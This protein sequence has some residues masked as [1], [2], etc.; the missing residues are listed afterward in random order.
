MIHGCSDHK[1]LESI[2]E[3][4]DYIPHVQLWLE[5]FTTSDDTVEYRKG[6]VEIKSDFISR[7]PEP[8][9]NK[10]TAVGLLSPPSR[11]LVSSS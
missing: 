7:L 9:T 3:L 2:G 5:L 4:G 8:A 6:G 10:T 1:A 11:T